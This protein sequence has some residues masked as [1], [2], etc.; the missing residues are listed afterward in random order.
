MSNDKPYYSLDEYCKK[1]YHEKLYKISLDAGFTCPNRDGT[2]DTRGCIFCSAG[3]SGDFATKTAGKTVSKQ[4]D[5]GL[6]LFRGKKTGNR[7]IAY[8]Q[9]FTNT[10]A[11]VEHLRA[12]YTEALSHDRIAGISIATRPDCLGE[13]VLQ[14]LNELRLLFPEKFIWI[15]LGLQTIHEK[16]A[17][18]IRR[19]YPLSVFED[20]VARLHA[21]HIPVIVHVILGLPGE[22]EE[23]FY[24]TIRY[25]NRFP[26]FGIKLQLLH[27]LS[28]TDLADYMTS[29]GFP[30]L[31]QEEYLSLLM[32][33]IALL[34]PDI[35]IHRLTGDGPKDLLL[36]PLW[37][38]NKRN[39]LNTLHKEMKEKNMYQ[40]KYYRK[41]AYVSGII[42]SI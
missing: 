29:V 1:T 8:F 36:A 11:P 34:S 4:I 32:N 13:P 39:V 18:F 30:V 16:T 28:G 17:D 23:M 26:I 20:A 41:D 14:L 3:G 9:A 15:E 38:L 35:V 21:I 24:E 2:L 33:C 7:F 27:V 22:T 12:L 31:M 5:E 19:G 6:L 42:H 37:S 10:Y 40:G 25:L